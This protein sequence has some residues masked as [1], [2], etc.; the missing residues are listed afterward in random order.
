[1]CIS[2]YDLREN[3]A[4][5]AR[6]DLAEQVGKIVQ[7]RMELVERGRK[8]L[9]VPN[10]IKTNQPGFDRQLLVDLSVKRQKIKLDGH[11]WNLV[12]AGGV[13]ENGLFQDRDLQPAVVL[14][15][16]QITDDEIV[17]ALAE[18]VDR[19]VVETI[20]QQRRK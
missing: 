16:G 9:S 18:F 8:V 13:A 10:C 5:K 20:R 11:D 14:E 6:N 19:S 2:A 15:Q 12:I 4:S 7:A 3:L 17:K 1:M